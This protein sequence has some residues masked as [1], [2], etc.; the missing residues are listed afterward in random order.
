MSL[1]ISNNT[2]HVFR[3]LAGR[4]AGRSCRSCGE[5]ILPADPF[6]RSEGVCRPCRHEAQ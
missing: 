3:A 4:E 1:T 5:P 6:G 2:W